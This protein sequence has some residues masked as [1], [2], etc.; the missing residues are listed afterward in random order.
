MAKKQRFRDT[1]QQR[2]TKINKMEK[3]RIPFATSGVKAKAF[4]TD[5]FMLLMPLLYL[6]IYVIFDGL[7]DVA[8]HRLEA[9]GYAMVP[10]LLILTVFMFKDEGRTP[11]ARA[12]SLK[13]I[14][15]HTLDK[16]SL[17]SIVF[18][19]VMLLFSLFIPIFWLIPFF[20][21]DKRMLHDFL[22]ATCVIV[23]PRP[24]K[25]KVFKAK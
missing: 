1:K 2:E 7:E 20:R 22:S 6:S 12:Q 23:D 10:F 15:F 13:V 21:K 24:P 11:G 8:H 16:P 14:N 9:W 25:E 18:R 17:F 3:P 19:N 4:L 5:I